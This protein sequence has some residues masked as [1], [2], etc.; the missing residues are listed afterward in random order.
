MRSD[1]QAQGALTT[2][3]QATS[4]DLQ[5]DS[6]LQ[7]RKS[8]SSRSA[9][10]TIRLVVLQLFMTFLVITFLVPHLLDDLVLSESLD[11]GVR[12]P[13]RVA[14]AGSPLEQLRQGV[15]TVAADEIYRTTH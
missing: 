5:A 14:A 15:S 8:E 12:A 6:A 2:E 13:N 3:W 7:R 4:D 10:E 11:R 1:R 9:W